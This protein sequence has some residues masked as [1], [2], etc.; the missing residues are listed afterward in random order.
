MAPPWVV[1]SYFL[2]VGLGDG[3]I[4]LLLDTSKPLNKQIVS[5]V[6]I[7][8]GLRGDDRVEAAVKKIAG[9]FGFTDHRHF[10]FNAVVVTHW[11]RDHYEATMSM[12]QAFFHKGNYKSCQWISKDVTVFYL[13]ETCR[14]WQPKDG[15]P[16]LYVVDDKSKKLKIKKQNKNN[17]T[18]VLCNV[19]LGTDCLGID[20]FSGV[21]IGKA[22]VKGEKLNKILEK[23]KPKDATVLSRPMLLCVGID[24]E[25]LSLEDIPDTRATITNASSMMCLLLEWKQTAKKLEV[26]LYTGGDAEDFQEEVLIDWLVKSD[27]K[28]INVIKCGHHGSSN[29]TNAKFF[30]LQPEY[31]VVSVGEDHGH[32]S[33]SLLFF[34]IAYFSNRE[35]FK[36]N[37]RI[38]STRYPYWLLETATPSE[39]I[40]T[41]H[42]NIAKLLD[43]NYTEYQTAI[44]ELNPPAAGQKKQSLTQIFFGDHQKTLE[45]V[46]N[47]LTEEEQSE[48]KTWYHK[49]NKPKGITVKDLSKQ[50]LKTWRRLEKLDKEK[51]E[52]WGQIQNIVLRRMRIYWSGYGVPELPISTS[53][54]FTRFEVE[55][56]HVRFFDTNA[57]IPG[58]SP[59]ETVH[60]QKSVDIKTKYQN[61]ANIVDAA[62][63]RA[64]KNV[65]DKLVTQRQEMVDKIKKAQQNG[66]RNSFRQVLDGMKSK[67]DDVFLFLMAQKNMIVPQ[68]EAVREDKVDAWIWD[69]L[70]QGLPV[71][72]ITA[73][74]AKRFD[75]QSVDAG[76]PNWLK[77][78]LQATVVEIG[79]RNGDAAPWNIDNFSLSSGQLRFSS[80]VEALKRQFGDSIANDINFRGY[81]H[82]L[83]AVIL[84]LDLQDTVRMSLSQFTHLISFGMSKWVEGLLEN[85]PIEFAT[86]G[87][88]N[89]STTTDPKML[90]RSGVWIQPQFDNR[91]ILRLEGVIPAAD[92]NVRAFMNFIRD[93]LDASDLSEL[94]VIGSVCSTLG[95]LPLEA[96]QYS[97]I[98]NQMAVVQESRLSLVGT[99]QWGKSNSRVAFAA[100]VIAGTGISLYLQ[101][102][103]SLTLKD[104]ADWVVSKFGSSMKGEDRAEA[105]GAEGG[106]KEVLD[107]M[108]KSIIPRQLSLHIGE[109]PAL[110]GF[111]VDVEL[112]LDIGDRG[113]HVPIHGQVKWQ[114]GQMELLGEI[115]QLED[116]NLVPF[117]V[118]PFRESFSEAMPD[119]TN[120]IDSIWLPH[121]FDSEAKREDFPKAIPLNLTKA[122][123]KVTLGDWKKI[124]I[125][126]KLQCLPPI[127]DDAVMPAIWLD[128]LQ[129]LFMKD[130][131]AES[132]DFELRGNILLEAP[133]YITA[134]KQAASVRV[135]VGYSDGWT[136]SADA[137]NLQMANL[138]TL[139]PVDGSN[140]ALM[141]LMGKILIPDFSIAVKFA[142]QRPSILDI[143]A[144]FLIGPLQLGIKYHHGPDEWHLK[145]GV[146]EAPSGNPEATL[147]ELLDDFIHDHLDSF[148]DFIRNLK[149]PLAKISANLSCSS[150]SQPGSKAKV[151]VFSFMVTVDKFNFSF[152]QMQSQEGAFPKQLDE[153]KRKKPKRIL[154][155][156]LSGLPAANDIPIVQDLPQPFDEMDFL[157]VSE[158]V[159]VDDAKF[160]NQEV[161]NEKSLPPLHWKTTVK[162]GGPEDNSKSIALSSGCHFQLI[163]REQ[164][165]PTCALDYVFNGSK[166]KDSPPNPPA[167]GEKPSSKP[168]QPGHAAKGGA[169]MTPVTRSSRGLTIR[170]MGLKMQG[171][172]TLCITLDAIVALGPLAFNLIGFQVNIDFEKFKTPSDITALDVDFSLKGMAVAF[173][174]PPAMLAG[175]FSREVHG[176]VKTYSGGLAIGVGVWQFLAAGVYEEHED[177]KTVFVFAKLNGPLISFGYAEINGIVGGFGYNSSLRFP[178]IEEVTKFPFVSMNT[179]A[180]NPAVGVIE[181]F[182]ALTSTKGESAW[183]KSQKDSIWLAAGLGVKA[184]QMLEVQAVV[185]IDLS[186]K[187][188]VGIFAEAV[189]ILPKGVSEDKAFLLLD[190][191]VSAVFDPSVGILSLRGELTPRSFILSK[192]CV[193]SGG[194]ALVFF[195]PASGHEGDWVFT[196]GGYHPAFRAPSHYPQN[197]KRVGITWSYDEDISISGEAYFAITP[198]AVMGGGRLDLV[199]HSGHTHASF[200]AY[201]DFLILFEPFQFQARV[202]VNVFAS[203]RIGFGILSKDVSTEISADVDL[204]GPPVAGTAHLHF[205]FFSIS[206]RFGPDHNERP[207]LGWKEVYT[208]VKQCSSYNDAKEL[209]EHLVS[210]LQGRTS[211]NSIAPKPKQGEK[212]PPELWVVR[213]PVFEFEFMARFPLKEVRYNNKPADGK[214]SARARDI[215]STP[216]K[217]GNPFS[218]SELAISIRDSVQNVDAEFSLEPIVKR[219]P[220]ALWNKYDGNKSLLDSDSTIEH[221]MGVTFKPVPSHESQENLPPINMADFHCVPISGH[222][223]KF[224][225]AE[226]DQNVNVAPAKEGEKFDMSDVQPSQTSVLKLWKE[227]RH[228]TTGGGPLYP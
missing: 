136:L 223:M 137:V 149:I 148:P 140:H 129:L 88:I 197:V 99:L 173:S 159:T 75:I 71:S 214:V 114:P 45:E 164:N 39:C 182:A 42:L 26:Q 35:H 112:Q 203:A 213:A 85:I 68:V 226:Y 162:R 170:N 36:A 51:W 168:P 157:W 9:K 228:R 79:L 41:K 135:Y 211:T 166:H 143:D 34:I 89:L 69:F 207:P 131:T 163:L 10:K 193:L 105:S 161:F 73:G 116:Q 29:G 175:M 108:A 56:I 184:F 122:S 176:N 110:V 106:F 126:G 198:Q 196:A 206:V 225:T 202:G 49:L 8:G 133:N 138:Y 218:K 102:P 2:N 220:G 192:G 90:N 83:E 200:S 169:A 224:P 179:G 27:V 152:V 147:E 58:G 158:D 130:L 209:P 87:R 121:L 84:A 60:F 18:A 12:I 65:M 101:P 141:N 188:K 227:L 77:E 33:L 146:K 180:E 81:H 178:A 25:L 205:W 97:G 153:S 160:I 109:G 70:T 120:A 127:T 11:D 118:H 15:K 19:I 64:A 190:L 191:G 72:S 74:P 150:K 201:A 92:E 187:P 31:F 98:P 78:S 1:D 37:E 186:P 94:R 212:Q 38:H 46:Y 30:K 181:Q 171:K 55:W 156:S 119:P 21:F 82:D 123:V 204:H 107:K 139:L 222:E 52:L 96:S 4:H 111:Q 194:F 134:L 215:Y 208:L 7:D 61:S 100:T 86:P 48:Y 103:S 104:I 154:R 44:N 5:A 20:L 3:A 124:I 32:P 91:T 6:L 151:V 40:E 132:T 125:Q 174:K 57:P 53:G 43:K 165:K 128:E 13:P 216:M 113:K 47:K 195:L 76:G 115:W 66:R 183:F 144:T 93:H 95:G 23:A 24:F 62:K 50:D 167:E 155:F 189:A 80:S 219:V 217:S 221:V 17:E 54:L 145:G 28:K 117:N 59:P 14:T 67:K 210:L 63:L 177:Y 142:K 22:S 172:K 185:C 199:Y 16:K